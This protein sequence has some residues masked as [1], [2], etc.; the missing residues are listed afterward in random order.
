VITVSSFFFTRNPK[1]KMNRDP[2][3]KMNSGIVMPRQK[4][5]HKIKKVFPEIHPHFHVSIP[6][7]TQSLLSI[8]AT[9]KRMGRPPPPLNA[10]PANRRAGR[11]FIK[12]RAQPFLSAIRGHF[13]RPFA[14]RMCLSLVDTLL[15]GQT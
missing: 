2:K 13:S 8:S 5:K 14:S 9:R 6:A 3:S 4:E 10:R 7:K 11:S 12:E 15:I 1:S